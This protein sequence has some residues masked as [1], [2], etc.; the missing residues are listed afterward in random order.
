MSGGGGGW[1][2]RQ[3]NKAHKQRYFV[4]TGRAYPD[5]LRGANPTSVLAS[6]PRDRQRFY[7]DRAMVLS[8]ANLD[9]F[10]G[11][12]G[13]PIW[14]EHGARGKHQVGY[15]HHSWI[16]E[17]GGRRGLKIIARIPLGPDHPHG[18]RVAQMVRAG[19]YKGFSVG[20]SADL[21]RCGKTL[22][23]NSKSFREIS[24]VREPFFDD[25]TLAW[26]V[27]AAKKQAITNPDHLSAGTF[28]AAI[29]ASGE[30]DE[31]SDP[32]QQQQ[33]APSV[34]AGELLKQ[35]DSLKEQAAQSSE[36]ER[37]RARQLTELQQKM[38]EKD[39]E[40]EA[41]RARD[42]KERAEYAASQRPV[43]EQ[44]IAG[45]EASMGG[46]DKL[47]PQTRRSYEETF[48]NPDFK[49]H[50]RA[51][52]AQHEHRVALEASKQAAEERL[53]AVTREKEE[54][55][56]A[57]TKT[58]AVLNHSRH[59]FAQTLSGSEEQE[60]QN[61]GFGERKADVVASKELHLN[62]MMSVQTP[63]LAE[64]PFLKHYGYGTDAEVNASASGGNGSDEL[65]PMPTHVPKPRVHANLYNSQQECNLPSSARFAHPGLFA[66][67]VQAY[68]EAPPNLHE[69]ARMVPD[70]FE[71]EKKY[72][73]EAMVGMM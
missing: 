35:A 4:V 25:C 11:T 58:T 43:F 73:A 70:K 24:L 22:S 45:L 57:V 66:W 27:E 34:D 26:S 50:A 20:Y 40:L 21:V 62:G 37:E 12:Q 18:E 3:Q 36:A 32:Q 5:V 39:R 8:D 64:L 19:H 1:S 72:E 49:H 15:V 42:Q 31:M 56:S 29:E 52:Q 69:F 46:K 41:F 67:M 28:F 51:F 17:D 14:E 65:R 71:L 61:P 60:R 9:Q 59:T 63:S 6:E 23:V 10:N 16:T 44:F 2:A 13:A 55:Q 53:A 48:C 38:A 68:K 54:L 7:H 33:Q 30:D 47:D